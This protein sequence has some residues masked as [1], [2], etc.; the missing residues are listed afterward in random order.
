MIIPADIPPTLDDAIRWLVAALD[1]SDL[2]YLKSHPEDAATGLHFTVGM[3]LRNRWALWHGS[4]LA[5]WFKTHHQIVH[6]DD[7][8]SILLTTLHR[9][10]NGKPWNIDEQVEYYKN[11]WRRAGYPDG[12]PTDSPPPRT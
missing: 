12:V 10:V 7:M 4:V 2:E 3:G 1:P 11:Y 8:S 6:A 9:E 5:E